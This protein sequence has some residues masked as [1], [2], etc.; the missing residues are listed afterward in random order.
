MYKNN[1]FYYITIAYKYYSAEGFSHVM[2]VAEYVNNNPMI[3]KD[4]KD[5]CI[6]LA[7]LHD[8]LED[9]DWNG[10]NEL[11]GYLLARLRLLTREQD[12]SYEDYIEKIAA[13]KDRYREVY[14]VKIADIKDH[15]NLSETLTDYLKD[16]YTKALAVLL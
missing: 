16:K 5:I 15:L 13:L 1:L 6:L 2:R 3:P 9:T 4:I 12:V 11:N 10:E 14:W 8:I 7:I